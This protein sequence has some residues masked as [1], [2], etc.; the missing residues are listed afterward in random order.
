M[1]ELLP[2]GLMCEQQVAL[3]QTS[4]EALAGWMKP[5]TVYGTTATIPVIMNLMSRRFFTGFSLGGSSDKNGSGPMSIL[6]GC[7]SLG[8][9]ATISN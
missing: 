2:L 8:L 5:G 3:V 4:S 9:R 6:T 1:H 7:F